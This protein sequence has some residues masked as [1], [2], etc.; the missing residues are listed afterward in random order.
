MKEHCEIVGGEAALD[1]TDEQRAVLAELTGSALDAVAVA[2]KRGIP[3]WT[4][5]LGVQAI[6]GGL[7]LAVRCTWTQAVLR[8]AVA[9]GR[10]DAN[11]Y[12]RAVGALLQGRYSVTELAIVDICAVLDAADWDVST[13]PA[14]ALARY[15]AHVAADPD[16]RSLIAYAF[17]W[18]WLRHRGGLRA[19]HFIVAVLDAIEDRRI[20]AGL[21]ATVYRSRLVFPVPARGTR[22][23]HGPAGTAASRP[24]AYIVRLKRNALGSLRR[25]LRSW[26]SQDGEF[27]SRHR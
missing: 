18:A 22:V 9:N 3:L 2:A 23:V 10:I 25:F 20:A 17:E 14:L 13:D 7:G 24:A 27:R 6:C 19:K 4:D 21:A 16:N 26:R 12:G 15:L 8:S 11:V 5:D 1:L